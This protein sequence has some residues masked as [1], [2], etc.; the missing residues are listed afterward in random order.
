M[1]LQSKVELVDK[2]DVEYASLN[3]NP[4]VTWIKFI[5]TDDRPNANGVR[6]PKEEFPNLIKTGIYMPVKSGKFGE[7]FLGHPNAWPLGTITHLKEEGDKIVGL[8]ALWEQEREDDVLSIK[9]AFDS[10]KDIN[11]SWEIAY[12]DEVLE[13]DGVK[14]LKGTA[15]LGTTIVDVPAYEGRTPILAVAEKDISEKWTRKYIND[16]P[17]SAFLYIEPGGKK[18]KEGKTVPRSLRHL[19]YKN[20]NGEIDPDHLRNAIARLSQPNTGKDWLTEGLRKRLLSKARKLLESLKKEDNSEM[21]E[22][23]EL[24]AK[25][26]EY[27]QAL[28]DKEKELEE[29][30]KFKEEVETERANAEK[31]EEIKNKFKEAGIEKSEDYFEENKDKLL[32]MD[33][34]A[35]E[36]MIQE[37]AVAL[38]S[39]KQEKVEESSK[40]LPDFPSDDVKDP[41]EKAKRLLE[42]LRGEK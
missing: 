42:K 10:G 20:K 22:L 23:E 27:E 34:A 14:V 6:I 25:I 7:E 3:L 39:A 29:L 12:E 21:E 9:E 24:K 40:P 30:R 1:R 2:Q 15:L 33:E 17:D 5:L 11:L 8:A 13:D 4:L 26:A 28:A 31:L 32:S 18:D 36:F 41:A 35:I 19:P 38:A 37:M 16:L